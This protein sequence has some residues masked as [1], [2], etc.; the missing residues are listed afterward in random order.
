ERLRIAQHPT[1]SPGAA[2]R[3]D[4]NVGAKARCHRGVERALDADERDEDRRTARVD[5]V[6]GVRLHDDRPA[7]APTSLR[8]L[9]HAQR[10]GERHRYLRA[11][12]RVSRRRRPW[13]PDDQRRWPETGS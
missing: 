10:A 13:S 11:V 6:I 12:V 7:S 9:A 2:V 3:Y 5:L 4:S 1:P 8:A